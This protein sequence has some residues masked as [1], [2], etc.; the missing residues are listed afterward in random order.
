MSNKNGVGRRVKVTPRK[1]V[2]HNEW[3]APPKVR[4][5]GVKR[6]AD[7]ILY[8]KNPM[9]RLLSIKERARNIYDLIKMQD[10]GGDNLMYRPEEKV[11]L[12]FVFIKKKIFSS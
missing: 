1:Y 10:D 8:E 7:G 6:F 4:L 5:T 9:N 11:F 2:S 12:I 3:K